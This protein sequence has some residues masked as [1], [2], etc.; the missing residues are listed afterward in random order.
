MADINV[1]PSEAGDVVG[2]NTTGVTTSNT[3]PTNQVATATNQAMQLCFSGVITN[4]AA[5]GV[6]TV[7]A[8]YNANQPNP[9][10]GPITNPDVPRGLSCTFNA[11]WDGGDVTIVGTDQFG[12]P[13]TEVIADNPGATV[14]SL[15]IFATVVSITKQTVGAAAQPCSVG[16]TDRLGIGAQLPAGVAVGI[17]A[18]DGVTEVGTWDVTYHGVTPT[19]ATNGAHDYSIMFPSSRTIIQDSHNHTQ[20]QH[21]HA[22]VDGGHTH[23]LA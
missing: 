20:D 4:P 10:P 14:N 15:N 16:T 11:A 13:L 2:S 1:T 8:N 9:F 21:L 12:G 7:H 5:L 23:T 6:A 17:L 22:V 18:C 3:T 19:T